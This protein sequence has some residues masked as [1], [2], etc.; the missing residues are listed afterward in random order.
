MPKNPRKVLVRIIVRAALVLVA[1]DVM[2]F[3]AVS[4]PVAHLETTAWDRLSAVRRRAQ[5]R[6]CAGERP[7][8]LHC[9]FVNFAGSVLNKD[10]VVALLHHPRSEHSALTRLQPGFTFWLMWV[11]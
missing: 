9:R 5:A 4:R 8:P 3:L 2:V 7:C 1:L 6:F 10:D 11:N